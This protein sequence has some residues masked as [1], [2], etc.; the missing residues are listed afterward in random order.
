MVEVSKDVLK[1]LIEG[2]L[3]WPDVKEITSAP[4]KD[5]D[6]FDKYIEILQERVPWEDRILL[7]I[8]PHLFI[9]EKENGERVVKCECGHE[10]GDYR[11]NWKLKAL[12]Y[13][14]DDEEKLEEIYPGVWK[15]DPEIWEIR[16]FYCPSCGTQ[17]EVESVPKGY[18]IIF[19]FLPDIDSFYS[20]W[21][22]KPL[23]TSVE[24]K[25]KTYEFIKEEWE[26]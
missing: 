13:V 8:G 10:F 22:G 26:G 21:L 7:P 19:D 11:V 6:R 20:E 5:S 12:I 18:P 16:E 1:S 3:P 9:V 15:P 2:K 24:F 4:I 14:R 23:R 25:D 17:L